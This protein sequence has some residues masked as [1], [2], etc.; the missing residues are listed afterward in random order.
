MSIDRAGAGLFIAG[1]ALMVAAVATGQALEDDITRQGMHAYLGARGAPGTVALGM[2]FFGFPAGLA[3]CVMGAA[4]SGAARGARMALLGL[5]A[6][7]MASAVVVVPL[8]FGR[9]PSTL[10]FGAG[11]IALLALLAAAS[12][13]WGKYRAGRAEAERAAVDLGGAG[14]LCFA[15][16]AWN[17]CGFGSMP[18]FALFPERAIELGTQ[19]FAVGQLKAI[20]ALLVLGWVFTVLGLRSAARLDARRQAPS[21]VSSSPARGV[22][23]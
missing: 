11:G 5:F 4:R 17:T 10:Y 9:E 3:L 13:Y 21:S 16:A 1:V 7:G 15:L 22:A 18:S 8:L 14:Y 23:P 6:L 20:M 19:A 12:W 2:L